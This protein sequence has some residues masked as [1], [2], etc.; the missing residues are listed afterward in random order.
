MCYTDLRQSW[1]FSDM[2][3]SMHRRLFRKNKVGPYNGIDPKILVSLYN[4]EV[5]Q[6]LRD[7]VWHYNVFCMFILQ[8]TIT[9]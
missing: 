3:D 1:S 8:L 7:R 6:A 5:D 4:K 9:N 2:I